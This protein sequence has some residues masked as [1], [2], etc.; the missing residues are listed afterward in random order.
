[1]EL[2]ARFDIYVFSGCINP[3]LSNWL[4]RINAGGR[5]GTGLHHVVEKEVEKSC[6]WGEEPHEE[7]KGY[8]FVGFSV[9]LYFLSRLC[10]PLCECCYFT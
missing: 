10:K 2:L 5:T 7:C 1:M 3:N 8:P 4:L 6:H 9:L